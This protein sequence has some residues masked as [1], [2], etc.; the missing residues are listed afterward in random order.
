MDEQ[1]LRSII[2]LI[3][4]IQAIRCF[5]LCSYAAYRSKDWIFA[6]WSIHYAGW[7]VGAT[8]FGFAY[9]FGLPGNFVVEKLIIPNISSIAM[10][11]GSEL[12]IRQ[13]TR[14]RVRQKKGRCD[15]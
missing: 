8:Y 9:F 7:M 11:G 13:A 14:V 15:V 5:C 10:V 1:T 6:G 2:L 3:S 4:L 12:V